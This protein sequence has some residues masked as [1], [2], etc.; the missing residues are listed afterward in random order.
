MNKLEQ[1]K[2]IVD[3]QFS[4]IHNLTEAGYEDALRMIAEQID[5]LYK[6]EASNED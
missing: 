5:A 1:I 2:K 3:W 4:G 6:M